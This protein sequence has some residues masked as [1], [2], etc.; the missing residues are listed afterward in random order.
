M[1]FTRNYD[2]L[3]TAYQTIGIKLGD[4][5]GESTN[6]QGGEPL[7]LI[8]WGGSAS[9]LIAGKVSGI[10]TGLLNFTDG[11][12]ESTGGTNY[13]SSYSNAYSTSNL[14]CGPGTITVDG[15]IKRETYDDYKMT[16]FSNSDIKFVSHWIDD[17]KY[18]AKD[19]TW[20]NTYHKVYTA[21]KTITINEIGIR[22][23]NGTGCLLYRRVLDA[24]V[25]IEVKNNNDLPVNFEITFTQTVKSGLSEAYYDT[26]VGTY[27]EGEVDWS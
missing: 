7:T 1:G 3:V 4:K 14:V 18:N 16:L 21:N 22:G 9:Y 5:S 17:I 25:T 13:E 6:D 23:W 8:N 24:P 15:E 10:G 11:E 12:N 27:E 26:N 20:T 19:N 2:N